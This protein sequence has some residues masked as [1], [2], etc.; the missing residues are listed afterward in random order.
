MSI[1][2]FACSAGHRRHARGA[3]CT[4]ALV[5]LLGLLAP[6]PPGTTDTLA[7]LPEARGT[8]AA[9]QPDWIHDYGAG[10]AEARRSGRPVLID[11]WADWCE[12]CLRMDDEVWNQK[13]LIEL[14]RKA[15]MVRVDIDR[16]KSSPGRYHLLSIPLMVFTDPWGNELGRR[17]G[18]TR[19]GPLVEV[20]EALV[21]VDFRPLRQYQAWLAEDPQDA[22][23]LAAIGRFYQEERLLDLSDRYYGQ[24]LD[25]DEAEQDPV[26]AEGAMIG[27]GLNCLIRRDFKDA[28]KRFRSCLEEVPEGPG[29]PMVLYGLM[30]A[31]LGLGNRDDAEEILEELEASF[32]DSPITRQAAQRLASATR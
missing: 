4:A 23:A 3:P 24:A 16:D 13:E 1:P 14:S 2:S 11:F 27:L 18:F 12:P 31:H 29:R 6:V 15:V 5:A 10:L 28:R 19:A 7:T 20:L 9:Q 17:E 25:S 21:P 32:P 26:V 8:P 30:L 22:S